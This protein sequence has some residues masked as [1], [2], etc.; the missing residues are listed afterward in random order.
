MRTI[1]FLSIAI[2]LIVGMIFSFEGCQ[3]DF[4]NE[5]IGPNLNQNANSVLGKKLINPYLVTNMQK[6]LNNLLGKSKGSNDTIIATHLYLKFIP[7]NDEELDRLDSL[8]YISEYP[9]DYEVV[10]GESSYRDPE[11]PENQPT[12]QYTSVKIGDPLPNVSYEII[13]E[14]YI[15][16]EDSNYS[17]KGNVNV[18]ALVTEALRI[19]DN[20]KSNELNNIKSSWRPSGTIRVYDNIGRRDSIG[21]FLG[22][23]IPLRGV[24]VEVRRWFTVH[25]GITN[26]NGYYSCDGT[27]SRPANYKIVWERADYNI[28]EGNWGQAIY[29]GP[30]Q[31]SEWNLNIG[32]STDTNKSMRYA[33]IHRAA[34]R[35]HYEDI[36][37]MRRPSVPH[38]INIC[39]YDWNGTGTNWANIPFF[40]NIAI[41]G[42]WEGVYKSTDIIFSTT[43]HELGHASHISLMNGLV[44][45]AQVSPIIYES[46]ASCI[47]WFITKIEYR[48]LG[49]L[50]YN[51]GNMQ[52][53]NSSQSHVYTPLFIDIFDNVNQFNDNSNRP[54]DRIYSPYSYMYGIE[55]LIVKN[56]YGL[57]SLRTNLKNSFTIDASDADIDLYMD[58]FNGY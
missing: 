42:K 44:Q 38:K 33:S 12:F 24:K 53:W 5:T 34:Y 49:N 6:A 35:Y 48:Y 52:S 7:L 57:S 39:Y 1:K 58:Y 10:E 22:N 28:R 25:T 51:K 50:D 54:N 41:Y 46:W 36:G 26:E 2:I 31:S 19:T 40:P 55:M 16:E 23:M 30:K 21:N 15:P 37:G 32:S 20:L 9:L 4:E 14:L 13:E 47:E 27:F 18:D 45:Y 3:K 8:N 29:N 11:V 17:G 56:S 43:I